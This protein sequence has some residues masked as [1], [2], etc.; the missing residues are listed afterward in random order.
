MHV[1]GALK[2]EARGEDIGLGDPETI[3]KHVQHKV[4]DD[5]GKGHRGDG[6]IE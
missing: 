2:V 4:R 6:I 5:S 3:L 1:E